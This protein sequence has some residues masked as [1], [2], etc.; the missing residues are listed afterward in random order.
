MVNKGFLSSH[1]GMFGMFVGFLLYICVTPAARRSA[2]MV[3][4]MEQF[5]THITIDT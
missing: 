3:R 2:R 4:E 5:A 1:G